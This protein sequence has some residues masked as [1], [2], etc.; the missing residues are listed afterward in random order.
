MFKIQLQQL[1][2]CIYPKPDVRHK[3]KKLITNKFS[4]ALLLRFFHSIKILLEKTLLYTEEVKRRWICRSHLGGKLK[5]KKIYSSRSI[6]ES[7]GG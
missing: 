5:K 2:V 4:Y 1:C 6:E 7:D 3:E